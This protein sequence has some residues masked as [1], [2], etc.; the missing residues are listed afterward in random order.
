MKS[1]IVASSAVT[2]AV[3][4]IGTVSIGEARRYNRRMT[5]PAP[6][7]HRSFVWLILIAAL[8]A[9]IGLWLGSRQFGG[10]GPVLENAVLYPQPRAAPDFQL[11]QVD[12]K[13][14]SIADWRGR[15]NVV[16]FGYASCPDV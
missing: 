3:V 11:Q 15:W 9:A 13:P 7:S 1:M 10:A 14:L 8:A 2:V 5:S 4:R 6:P 16:Y 12:G